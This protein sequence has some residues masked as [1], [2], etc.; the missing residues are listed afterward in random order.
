[1]FLLG[2]KPADIWQMSK[3]LAGK[4]LKR[5]GWKAWHIKCWN[6]CIF[7]RKHM[8][9]G[10]P[11]VF[12]QNPMFLS[13][14]GKTR[15]L[16]TN[17]IKKKGLVA[18]GSSLMWHSH[19]TTKGFP[20]DLGHDVL[21]VLHDAEWPWLLFDH[22]VD[23]PEMTHKS[24]K[25]LW[26]SDTWDLAQVDDE[27]LGSK[28]VPLLV[29]SKEG[30][31]QLSLEK[32]CSGLLSQKSILELKPEDNDWNAE[33]Q[34]N[35]HATATSLAE[36]SSPNLDSRKPSMFTFTREI[37]SPLRL[38]PL[39]GLTGFSKSPSCCSPANYTHGKSGKS[40]QCPRMLKQAFAPCGEVVACRV[41]LGSKGR[42]KGKSKGTGRA[43]GTSQ[44][45]SWRKGLAVVLCGEWQA[46]KPWGCWCQWAEDIFNLDLWG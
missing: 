26:R 41:N 40:G 25:K 20:G 8:Y 18:K 44:R 16:Y 33:N 19:W 13:D 17:P 12:G 11:D 45:S 22:F 39:S 28:R 2:K 36:S 32:I 34:S 5:L 24:Q 4:D 21:C 42:S 14:F 10:K 15:C 38:F 35:Y 27:L 9:L 30:R 7:S 43:L 46:D 1:M 29:G 6:D 31:A 37:G 23:A 3:Q